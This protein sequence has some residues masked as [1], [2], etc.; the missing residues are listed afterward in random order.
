MIKYVSDKD[1]TQ[2]I[3]FILAGPA[4]VPPKIHA[5]V[6]ICEWRKI[7][8]IAGMLD[9]FNDYKTPIRQGDHSAH[10]FCHCYQ[11]WLLIK[12]FIHFTTQFSVNIHRNPCIYTRC[13]QQSSH[14]PDYAAALCKYTPFLCSCPRNIHKV[15]STSSHILV[16]ANKL[17]AAR[18]RIG[19]CIETS[20]ARMWSHHFCT[21][22][23]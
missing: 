22:C 3:L 19:S 17:S 14:A 4:C 10:Y 15:C 8:K 9:Q 1:E 7:V 2:N 12:C 16:S 11:L 13:I 6:Q 21:S 23:I 5:L 20:R 18:P